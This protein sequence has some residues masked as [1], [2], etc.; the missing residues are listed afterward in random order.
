MDMEFQVPKTYSLCPYPFE[1]FFCMFY[2]YMAWNGRWLIGLCCPSTESPV[3]FHC[4]AI[5][6]SACHLIENYELT[7]TMTYVPQNHAYA[8]E[9]P[10]FKESH[11]AKC[12]W[13][14]HCVVIQHELDSTQLHQLPHTAVCKQREVKEKTYRCMYIYD[15]SCCFQAP[16]RHLLQQVSWKKLII[17]DNVGILLNRPALNN[18]IVFKLCCSQCHQI[19]FGWQK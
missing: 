3:S 7:G 4:C 19:I 5:Q 6:G 1:F 10:S 12:T 18:Y 9:I 13:C 15:M 11:C 2:I 16:A 17:P 8:A 14:T